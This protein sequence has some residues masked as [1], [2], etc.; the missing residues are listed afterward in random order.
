MRTCYQRQV[1]VVS[2]QVLQRRVNSQPEQHSL[3]VSAFAQRSTRSTR[4]RSEWPSENQGNENESVLFS[5]LL[6]FAQ[7]IFIVAS[8]HCVCVCARARVCVCA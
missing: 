4:F 2:Q 8:F 6:L 7:N 3:H 5:W 1:M